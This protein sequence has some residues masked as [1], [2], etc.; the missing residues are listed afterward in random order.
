[1]AEELDI[2]Q[3]Y[4]VVYE[5]NLREVRRLIR[6][7]ANVNERSLGGE[8]ALHWTWACWHKGDLN[9]VADDG[10]TPL[11]FASLFDHPHAVRKMLKKGS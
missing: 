11:H 9:I 1:M 5:G 7:R 2:H 6:S 10:N 4:R 8:T 3:L